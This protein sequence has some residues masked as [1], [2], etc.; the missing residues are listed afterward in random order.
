M[1]PF[2]KKMSVFSKVL[3][4][5]FILFFLMSAEKQINFLENSSGSLVLKETVDQVKVDEELSIF[6]DPEG[7]LTISEVSQPMAAMQFMP[8]IEGTPNL[9]YTDSVYWVRFEVENRAREKNWLVEIAAPSLD[10]VVLYSPDSIGRYTAKE[11]GRLLPVENR[12]YYHRNLVFGLDMKDEGSFVYYARIETGGPMQIP[13]T[14]W[15]E[16]AFEAKN[17]TIGGFIGIGGGV[18][19]VFLGYFIWQFI[20]R[21]QRS[22]F[23]FVLLTITLLFTISSMT[24]LTFAFIWPDLPRWNE[25]A[26]LFF[27]GLS[28]ILT[29]LFTESFLDVRRHLPS[30]N[31]VLQLLLGI[32]VILLA[33]LL[34]SYE[35]VRVHLP[36]SLLTSAV[37]SLAIGI[38]C[39]KKEIKYARYFL[40]A[41]FLLVFGIGLSFLV[42]MGYAPLTLRTR[43]GGFLS[44]GLGVC[45][46]AFALSDKQSVKKEE[47]IELERK[48]NERQRLAVESLKHAI[49]RK[50]ELLAITSHS[51]RTPLYGMI[52]IAEALQET[53]NGR[54]PQGLN[55]QLG[56]I[57]SSG[58]KLAHMVNDLLDY[59][60]LKQ[61]V[62]SIH[63][64]KVDLASIANAVLSICEPLA[65]EKKLKIYRDFPE[66]LPFIIA[67]G[68]R[69]QQILFNLIE[70]SIKYTESG[71]IVI[72]AKKMNDQVQISVRDTGKGIQEDKVSHL[73]EPFDQ[74]GENR[75]ESIKGASLGLSV[76]KRLVELQ[77][78]MLEIESHKGKGSIFSFTLPIYK[79]EHVEE[80]ILSENQEV[81]AL[82][83]YQVM[84]SAVHNKQDRHQLKVLVIDHGDVNRKMLMHQLIQTGYDVAGVATGQEAM[85]FVSEQPTDL[86]VL[87]SELGDMT[88]DEFCRHIRKTYALTELPILM[89]SESDEVQS[90][91]MAFTAGANDYLVKPCDKEEFLLRVETLANLRSLTKEITNMNYLLERNI[92]ERTLALEIT[93]MNLVTVN[94]EIQEIEKARNDMLSTISHEL[95]TPITL[96]HS[97][98]QAVKESLIDERNPRYLDMIHNKLL[99]LERLTEDLVELSKYKSGN[100]TLRFQQVRLGD[101]LDRLAVGMEADV[102]QSGRMFEYNKK[103]KKSSAENLMLLI[104]A[105]R[106]DQ[107]FSNIL[108]NAVK[109]TSSEDGKISL[110][111]EFHMNNK[112]ET[113]LNMDGFDG[114]V[115]IEV[116]DTGCGIDES[117]LPHIFDRF[118]KMDEKNIHK[119]SGLGLA[120]AKEIVLSHKGEIWAESEVGKGSVFYI[121]LPLTF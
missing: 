94:D 26:V 104:D 92:K 3:F 121:A 43:Y 108:W 66:E 31:R 60:K 109:H 63:L 118:F 27:I 45:Y 97:Y 9:G 62:L 1:S 4:I 90:K 111:V 75:V 21:S 2:Y 32:N 112:S 91:S 115:I 56:N 50:D 100:M 65:K 86:I 41:S 105:D 71:E 58:K 49:N 16:K 67:D 73:F 106:I 102:T 85:D 76:S 18:I 24:G 5:V 19:L 48:A 69:V 36:V 70:N 7:D 34:V 51:L 64:D 98:I 39:T 99:L 114:E 119:G 25:I 116:A 107:V 80:K 47:K 14:V 78:G 17:R 88:A 110:S 52:G 120:I 117:I 12:D 83:S 84:H 113:V 101:W 103:K 23:Y 93:N 30:L 6:E 96:I 79:E 74:N 11:S 8:N 15:E 38:I 13:V 61:N 68:D 57:V 77:G 44:I 82:P 46:A 81:E 20:Q 22:Y 29:L 10:S 40:M 35:F 72:S 95:G 53:E 28:S 42:V 89:M 33:A 37:L 55:Q 87:E 54:I 59:S